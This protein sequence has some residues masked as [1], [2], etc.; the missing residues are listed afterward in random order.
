[1]RVSRGSAGD[2]AL[3][4]PSRLRGLLSRLNSRR[5]ELDTYAQMHVDAYL[6]DRRS[7]HASKYLLLT[8]IE[9]A[10]AIANHVIAFS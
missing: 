9:D 2:W 8:A 6:A 7:V 1:M 10:L 4:D 3:V 5:Q